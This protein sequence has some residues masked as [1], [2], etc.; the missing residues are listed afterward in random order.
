[1]LEAAKVSY[2][3]RRY[4]AYYCRVSV[5]TI[6]GQETRT[7]RVHVTDVRHYLRWFRLRHDRQIHHCLTVSFMLCHNIVVV[8]YSSLQFNLCKWPN[9]QV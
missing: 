1:M 7:I 4:V 9:M 3:S 8:V 5:S 2:C 6:R